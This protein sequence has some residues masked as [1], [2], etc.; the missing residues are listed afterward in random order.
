MKV[1]THHRTVSMFSTRHDSRGSWCCRHDREC[2]SLYSAM[3]LWFTIYD[4]L[5]LSLGCK[6]KCEFLTLE[7][8]HINDFYFSLEIESLFV[9]AHPTSAAVGYCRYTLT[10][11]FGCF[12]ECVP[13]SAFVRDSTTLSGDLV[14]RSFFCLSQVVD[15]PLKSICKLRKLSSHRGGSA[16]S[17]MRF[18]NR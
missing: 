7:R 13:R 2:V 11:F 10:S 6:T 16:S 5:E 8:A 1:N 3:L 4:H 15:V 18:L 14:C 17:S 12:A 9:S